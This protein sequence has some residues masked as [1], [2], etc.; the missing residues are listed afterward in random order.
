M[1]SRG[2]PPPPPP[3]GWWILEADPPFLRGGLPLGTISMDHTVLH[4]CKAIAKWER[5]VMI[6]RNHCLPSIFRWSTAAVYISTVNLCLLISDY[7]NKFSYFWYGFTWHHFI[8]TSHFLLLAF[9]WVGIVRRSNG[10]LLIK[11]AR[12]SRQVPTRAASLSY[13]GFK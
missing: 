12:R 10:E 4:S 2:G 9:P 7:F 1:K 13:F 3:F 5:M 8:S 6:C 11:L